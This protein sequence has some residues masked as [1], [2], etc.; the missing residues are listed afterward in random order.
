M[1][2]GTEINYGHGFSEG[3]VSPWRCFMTCYS[4]N[5]GRKDVVF[6]RQQIHVSEGFS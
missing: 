5:R 3:D 6:W 4:A 1:A 2:W